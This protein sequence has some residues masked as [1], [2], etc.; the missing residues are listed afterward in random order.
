[1][2]SWTDL[3]TIII[4]NPSKKMKTLKIWAV[5]VVLLLPIVSTELKAGSEINTAK[6]VSTEMPGSSTR[7]LLDRLNEIDAMDKSKLTPAE[8]KQLRKEVRST[9]KEIKEIGGGVYISAGAIILIL[10]LLIILM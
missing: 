4:F 6:M 10:I 5:T 7:R 9:K 8:K 2:Q 1:M 3:Y